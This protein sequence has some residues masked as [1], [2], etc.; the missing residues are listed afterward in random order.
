MFHISRQHH[1][2]HTAMVSFCADMV[3]SDASRQQE[4]AALVCGQFGG[5]RRFCAMERSDL[6]FGGKW[7]A[8]WR[9][10]QAQTDDRTDFRDAF[11]LPYTGVPVRR[12]A[13]ISLHLRKSKCYFSTMPLFQAVPTLSPRVM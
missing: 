6:P 1:S 5:V 8:Q 4:G 7:S 10:R 11:P 9:V 12:P 3:Q 13:D 2:P